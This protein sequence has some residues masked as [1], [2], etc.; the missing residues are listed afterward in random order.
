MRFSKTEIESLV[1]IAES[2]QNLRAGDL[3]R[4]LN[5][6]PETLSRAITSLVKKGLLE[7]VGKEITIAGTPTAE[8]FKKL[9]FAHRAS[10]FSLLLADGRTDLLSRIENG[11]KSA[12]D[13]EKETSIP[14]KTIY[15]YLR[16][17]HHLGIVRRHKKGRGRVFSFNYILW[18]ELKDFVTALFDYQVVRQIPREGLLIKIYE[19]NVLFKSL[20]SQDATLTSFS[21][22]DDYVIE[23]GLRD[24]Y[25]ALPKRKLT[26]EEVFVHSLDSAEDHRQRL[27]CMLFYLKNIDK[28]KNVEHPIKKKL[29][30]VLHGKRIEGYPTMEEIN[31]KADLCGIKL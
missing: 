13:L 27:F 6:R 15:R 26:I 21:A 23:L 10:L 24:N 12:E 9:Y 11:Q 29:K 16:D 5:L 22:F 7:R 25:Y 30:K 31:D 3:S 4:A 19:D 28:L 14:R 1:L 20:R 8:M 2:K 18:K 17:F